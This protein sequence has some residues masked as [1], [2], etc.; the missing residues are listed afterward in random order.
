MPCRLP[1]K[2]GGS[3][4]SHYRIQARLD[5]LPLSK[6]LV[7]RRLRAPRYTRK[8]RKLCHARLIALYFMLRILTWPGLL[9]ILR[10]LSSYRGSL[11]YPLL[12]CQRR[13][14]VAIARCQYVWVLSFVCRYK[15]AS[16]VMTLLRQF[17]SQLPVHFS[18]RNVDGRPLRLCTSTSSF[19]QNRRTNQR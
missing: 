4:H 18:Q 13:S 3:V 11:V 16:L 19:C 10:L 5:T 15:P 17:E 2:Y 12:S 1:K 9:H 14:P 8:P 7:S 6:Q